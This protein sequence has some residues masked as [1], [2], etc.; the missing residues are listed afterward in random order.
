M[1]SAIHQTISHRIGLTAIMFSTHKMIRITLSMVLC[2]VAFSSNAG[3][4]YFSGK[5]DSSSGSVN[6]EFINFV[7]DDQFADLSNKDYGDVLFHADSI[8]SFRF[9]GIDLVEYF[10][11]KE[12]YANSIGYLDLLLVLDI[13]TQNLVHFHLDHVEGWDDNVMIACSNCSL[14]GSSNNGFGWLDKS[15]WDS[16]GMEDVITWTNVNYTIGKYSVPEPSSI[17]LLAIA[18]IGLFFKYRSV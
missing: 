8:L 9:A 16:N 11:N 12:P 1:L 13:E 2:L 18:I 14:S 3:L 15:A 5:G 6:E 10:S 17:S 7:W 4:M